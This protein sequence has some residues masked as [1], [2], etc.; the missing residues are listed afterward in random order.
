MALTKK[1]NA[2][3]PAKKNAS[4]NPNL[5]TTGA[6][7][8]SA[9]KPANKPSNTVKLPAPCKKPGTASAPNKENM[10]PNP[11]ADTTEVQQRIQPCPTGKAKRDRL[12]QEQPQESSQSANDAT[13]TANDSAL[14]N[15]PPEKPAKKTKSTQQAA[16]KA[17]I[18]PAKRGRHAGAQDDAT[19]ANNAPKIVSNNNQLS[20]IE[21]LKAQLA[22]QKAENAML[23][24]KESGNSVHVIPDK[25]LIPKPANT[26]K[27]AQA[28][29]M[30]NAASKCSSDEYLRIQHDVYHRIIQL[31]VN[32][33][34]DTVR[35]LGT[36]AN[37]F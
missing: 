6:A 32:P 1:P 10:P 36:S 31:G 33:E 5:K 8:A 24:T 4:K 15:A 14:V 34:T 20:E 26:N 27:L 17:P 22:A 2:S 18:A 19:P 16:P 25:D 7:A 35:S 28:M 13:A 12:A 21:T 9:A 37:R 29:Q 3:A 23:K 11:D 30:D